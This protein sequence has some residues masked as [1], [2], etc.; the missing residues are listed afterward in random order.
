MSNHKD[1]KHILFCSFSQGFTICI[2]L[3]QH[4][5]GS[6]TS[7]RS[8]RQVHIAILTDILGD[9]NVQ[10]ITDHWH[11]WNKYRHL[12]CTHSPLVFLSNVVF[13]RQINQVDHRFWSK[14][15]MFVQN[16]NLEV[17]TKGEKFKNNLYQLELI[18]WSFSSWHVWEGYRIQV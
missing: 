16:I 10:G 8:A 13:F 3:K 6:I 9:L 15:Q 17:R 4:V 18:L 2:V 5:S 14:K 12:T 7:N 11:M 1:G